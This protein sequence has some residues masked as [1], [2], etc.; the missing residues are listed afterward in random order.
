MIEWLT[1][2]QLDVDNLKSKRKIGK[3]N[4]IEYGRRNYCPYSSYDI[5]E[6]DAGFFAKVN[7]LCLVAMVSVLIYTMYPVL[8]YNIIIYRVGHINKNCY[9]H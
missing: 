8:Q 1:N 9:F 4:N 2:V 6:P 5:Q 7:V 3:Q